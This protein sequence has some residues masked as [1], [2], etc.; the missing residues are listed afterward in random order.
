VL[1][2]RVI[3]C[4]LLKGSGL[5]KT[6]KFDNARYVG[7][8]LNA[9]RIFNDKEV[10][11]I[12]ILD[13]DAHERPGRIKWD[14]VQNVAGEC[15]MPM[16]YGG[17]VTRVDEFKRLFSAGAEKV[18]VNTAAAESLKLVEAAAREFGSQ[19]IVVGIDVKK[20]LFGKYAV[21]TH[22]G[23]KKQRTDVI[24]YVREAEAAGAGEILLTSVDRDGTGGGYDLELLKMVTGAV[25]IPVIACGGAGRL[26]DFRAAVDN[27]AS[28]VAAGS[29]FV[30]HG[31]H[32]AVLITYPER[33]ELEACL[34]T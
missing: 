12:I 28:A 33:H 27:G 7:D 30:F 24:A 3:P 29:M 8:I 14:V 10:D 20:T 31:P 26:A 19:S 22:G 18:S 13:I 4:L 21:V 15:F 11:E 9:V 5:V 25:R 17:G 23:S 6:V 2:T 34:R 1:T 32:R 16:C